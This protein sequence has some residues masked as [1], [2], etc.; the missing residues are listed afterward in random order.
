MGIAIPERLRATATMRQPP[1]K[2]TNISD[3]PSLESLT[4]LIVIGVYKKDRTGCLKSINGIAACIL[5]MTK[6]KTP[7]KTETN[8][9][10]TASI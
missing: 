10:I 2:F 7:Q 4:H 6:I 3:G 9:F 5:E 1:H 8:K